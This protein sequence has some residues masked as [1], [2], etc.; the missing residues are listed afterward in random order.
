MFRRVFANSA[1]FVV[2]TNSRLVCSNFPEGSKDHISKLVSGKKLVVFMKGT[3]ENPRCGFSNAVIQILKMHGVDKFD[4]HDVLQSEDVRQGVK[5]YSS[6]PT[7]PQVFINGE[8]VGGCDIMIEMHQN[9]QLIKE[10]QKIDI[11]SLLDKK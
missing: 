9:G 5:D 7:L 10:L 1:K 8:F 2:P 11:K 6:W 3:P 4:S